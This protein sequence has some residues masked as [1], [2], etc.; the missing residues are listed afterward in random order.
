MLA[1]FDCGFSIQQ[2]YLCVWIVYRAALVLA[3]ALAGRL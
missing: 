3:C 1:L 2:M